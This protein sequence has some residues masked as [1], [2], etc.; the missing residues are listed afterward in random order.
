MVRYVLS[1]GGFDPSGGAGVLA[2]AKTFEA[3]GL[4][5]LAV[6]SANTIQTEDSFAR[7]EWVPHGFMEAQLLALLARYPVG[8]VKFGILES[9]GVLARLRGLVEQ[10]RPGIPA[11]VDPVLRATAS[12]APLGGGGGGEYLQALQPGDL[13][14]PNA[15]E[16]K[17]LFGDEAPGSV[18]SRSGLSLLLK[19]GHAQR[20]DDGMVCDTLHTPSGTMDFRIARAE[21]DKHGT[22]CVLSSAIAARLARGEDLATACRGAQAY[23]GAYLRSEGGRLGRHYQ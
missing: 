5:G 14:T 2:D 1:I 6:V 10:R 15:I 16:Y 18:A 22:G 4:M 7:C 17:I 19:G 13:L 11:V 21:G 20:A 12:D 8:A 9:T 23:V 3:H